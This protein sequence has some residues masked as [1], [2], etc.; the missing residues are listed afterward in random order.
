MVRP[1]LLAGRWLQPGDT[2]A[3]VVNEYWGQS[4]PDLQVGDEVVLQIA[5]RPTT[6]R[7]VGLIRGV[8][9]RIPP[10]PSAYLPYGSLAEGN[11]EPELAATVKVRTTFQNQAGGRGSPRRL[12]GDSRRPGCAPS[13]LAYE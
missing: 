11:G 13:A 3:I 5:G 10:T 1:T 7:V 12:R 2:N 6:R 8:P 4:E 9:N